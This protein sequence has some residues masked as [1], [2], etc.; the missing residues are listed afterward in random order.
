MARKLQATNLPPMMTLSSGVRVSLWTVLLIVML[1]GWFFGLLGVVGGLLLLPAMIYLLGM[2]PTTATGIDLFSRVLSGTYGCL[3]YALKGQVD[4]LG[5]LWLFLG[6]II[7]VQICARGAHY[8]RGQGIRL[9][10]AIIMA[11]VGLSVV[12]MQ[13]GITGLSQMMLLVAI[14]AICPIVIIKP[15]HGFLRNRH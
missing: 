7:G 1:T 8:I 6:I 15:I 12:V 11:M 4:F 14:L 9:F 13:F 2:L 5:V 3:T 10:F